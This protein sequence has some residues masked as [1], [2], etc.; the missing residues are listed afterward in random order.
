M[1][2]WRRHVRGR[3]HGRK[4]EMGM[5]M[6]EKIVMGR[7]PIIVGTWERN[8]VRLPK[9]MTWEHVRRVR[10]VL[11][12]AWLPSGVLFVKDVATVAGVGGRR[13]RKRRRAEERTKARVRYDWPP[14]DI[15]ILVGI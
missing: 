12:S 2:R 3:K 5:R 10:S 14:A 11:G 13:G 8:R 15:P 6:L 7:D 4:S 9:G 1:R